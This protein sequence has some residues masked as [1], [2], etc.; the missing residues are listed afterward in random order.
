MKNTKKPN[1]QQRL[2]LVRSTIRR[3]ETSDLNEV[4]GGCEEAEMERERPTCP[5]YSCCSPN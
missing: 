1:L 2:S 5:I 3:L 4:K